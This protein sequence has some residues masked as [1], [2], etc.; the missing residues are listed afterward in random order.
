MVKPKNTTLSL[1]VAENNNQ[2]FIK[3]KLQNKTLVDL[4]DKVI[5]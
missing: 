5:F 2:C 3:P 4:E 1:N